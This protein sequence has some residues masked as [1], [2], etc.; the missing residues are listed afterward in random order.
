MSFDQEQV[1]GIMTSVSHEPDR[2]SAI[3]AL[4]AID[5]ALEELLKAFLI[6]N[7]PESIFKGNSP[8]AT[9]SARIDMSFSMGLISPNEKRDLHLMRKVRNKFAHEIDHELKFEDDP[10]RNW[11]QELETPKPIISTQMFSGGKDTNRNRFD[12]TFA[13]LFS[14][15]RHTRKLSIQRVVSPE[16]SYIKVKNEDR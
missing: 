9:L 10:I 14:S 3:L 12:L 8:L 7:T 4:A 5:V 13:V 15:I 1:R 2:S 16:N 6:E 11:I